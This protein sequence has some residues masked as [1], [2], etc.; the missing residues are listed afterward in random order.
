MRRLMTGIAAI[1]ALGVMLA[2]G[3]G[4]RT[5][6]AGALE[7]ITSRG[8]LKIGIDPPYGVMEYFDDSGKLVGIDV[9][10]AREISTSL[11][12]TPEFVRM[13]FSE[14]FGAIEAG[15]IDVAISAVSITRERQKT[16]LFSVPYL[17][18]S[19]F[20]VARA[21][22]D[23]LQTVAD[24]KTRKIGVLKGTT[25]AKF[26]AGSDLFDAGNIVTFTKNDDRMAALVE[27]KIDVAL[28][29]FLTPGAFALK[30][31]GDP[32]KRAF[33][34]V[35]TRPRN[36]ALVERIDAIIRDLKRSGRLN[37][38]RLSHTR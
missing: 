1:A 17:D 23:S 12:V 30:R 19:L 8:V 6:E 2:L 34:G 36:T 10:L 16:Y 14:L 4:A 20:A 26:A 38:I 33:Y 29:H 31:V 5:A 28:V 35:V 24:M 22:D 13:P 27:G 3:G 32:L 7:E 25:G 11:G 21:D 9:D 18:A 37:E 15:K